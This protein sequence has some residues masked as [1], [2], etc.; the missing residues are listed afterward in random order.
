MSLDILSIDQKKDLMWKNWHL[1]DVEEVPFLIEIGPVH[2]A[3]THFFYDHKAELEWNINF[4]KQRDGIY[5]YGMPNIKPNQGINI[6]ASAFGCKYTVN[7][8]ADP[9]IKPMISEE[10]VSD[11]YKLEVPDPVNSVVYQQAYDRI[12]FLQSNSDFPLRLVNV[13][14]PLVT[15]SLI[16]DYTSFITS[17]IIYPKEVHVLMDKVTEATIAYIR[18]QLG[19][20]KNLFTMG[21]EMLYIPKEIGV[22][23]SD[24]TAALMSPNLYR[25]F[26]VKY[27]SMISRAFG[28]IVVHSC[29]DVQNVVEQMMEVEGIRGLDLTI[30]QTPNWEVIRRAAAGKTALNLRHYY[31]DHANN[32]K[33]DQAEYAKKLIDFFGRK[34]I[35][36]QTSTPTAEEARDL[37]KKLHNI[38]SK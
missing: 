9:W 24:D 18:E 30:P 4:H 16:W 27:N 2:L 21:H 26:G 20:I 17:T 29:G 32:T 10:N 22:R 3:T 28:G 36:I 1:Q 25:E 31:W 38:L 13:P 19:R 33:V 11:V 23:I 37:G 8:V 12:E 14:S 5:D 15:A 34:G 7:D 35:F 6:I